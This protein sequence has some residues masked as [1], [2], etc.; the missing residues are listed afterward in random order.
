[1]RLADLAGR[2]KQLIDRRGGT[3]SLKQDADELRAIAGSKGSFGDKAKQAAEA[4]KEPGAAPRAE[5]DA[6][7]GP[8]HAEPST[9]RTPSEKGSGPSETARKRER[10]E[11]R[12]RRG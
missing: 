1:M 6:A 9:A 10:R 3:E 8:T 5:H 2:A 12:A 11:R 4:V 7:A